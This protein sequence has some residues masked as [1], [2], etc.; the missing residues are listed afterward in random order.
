M[1]FGPEM[2]SKCFFF[3]NRKQTF[4]SKSTQKLTSFVVLFAQI[5]P[6]GQNIHSICLC[7]FVN[8]SVQQYVKKNHHLIEEVLSSHD[9][10]SLNRSF[11][12]CVFLF[13]KNTFRR[14]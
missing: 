5:P 6:Y 13:H 1:T 10:W 7:D 14:L 9:K 2:K 12:I 3:F 4:Q 11:N 8:H